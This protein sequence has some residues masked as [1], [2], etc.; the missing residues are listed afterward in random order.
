MGIFLGLLWRCLVVRGVFV[1]SELICNGGF[2][3]DGEIYV[4]LM[5]VSVVFILCVCFFLF[6]LR[7]WPF[8]GS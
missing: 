5:L 4:L 3:F 8:Y 7:M 6:S 1:L 2:Y